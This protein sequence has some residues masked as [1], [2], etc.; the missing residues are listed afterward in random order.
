MSSSQYRGAV[1]ALLVYDITK[2]E[3]FINT[4][5]WLRKAQDFGEN[6]I[7]ISLVG[8]KCDP[9]HDRAVTTEEAKEFAGWSYLYQSGIMV[10]FTFAVANKLLFIETSALDATNIDAAFEELLGNI[11]NIVASKNLSPTAEKSNVKPSARTSLI[12]PSEPQKKDS[13][14]CC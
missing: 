5:E 12:L 13:T 10:N 4:Q 1:G 6:Q 7:V 11:Y 8:N 3:T 2:R 9:N 14:G